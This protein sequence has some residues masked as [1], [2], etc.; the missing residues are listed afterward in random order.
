M[1]NNWNR[2][3]NAAKIFP[4]A[5]SR[6]DTQVFRFG[7]ELNEHVNPDV[8]QH[9]LDETIKIFKVFQCVLKRGLFWYYLESTDIMPVVREEYKPPCSQIYNN[10]K[11]DLLFEVTYYKKRI[12]LEVYH[13]LSDGTGAM[14]FLRMLLTKYLSRLHNIKEPTLDYDASYMQMSDD[15]F[16]KYYTEP[17]TIKKEHRRFACQLKGPRYNEDRIKVISGLV[18]AKALLEA[19]HKYDTTLTVFLCACL[20]N[21]ISE[22]L[23]A[24]AKK[25]PVVLGVPVNLRNHFPSE[26]ARNFFSLIHIEYDYRNRRGTFEDVVSKISEDLKKGL[27]RE[28]LARNINIYSAVEHNALAR[29]VPLPIKDICLKAAYHF[30]MQKVTAALSNVGVISMPQELADYIRS[31]H[32]IYGT[33]TLQAC[34]CSFGDALSISFTSPLISPEIQRRFFRKLTDL[35]IRVEISTNP[36]EGEQEEL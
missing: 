2:L 16:Q 33:N 28:N 24:R 36:V 19:A 7:C 6:A 35:G 1:K 13:V 5:A 8:L 21:S 25:M 18:S 15:S 32:V 27:S 4:S 10:N 34:V 20:M 14:Q 22:T 31:F 12:N 3:D 17:K 23:S 29:I 9:A 30:S 26:S 11:K